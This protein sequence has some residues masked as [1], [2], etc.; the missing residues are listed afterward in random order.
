VIAVD[1]AVESVAVAA[2]VVGADAE[3]WG[4]EL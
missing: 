1:I 2:L 4:G 3:D